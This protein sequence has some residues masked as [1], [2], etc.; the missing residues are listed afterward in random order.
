MIPLAGIINDL[1]YLDYVTWT[2]ERNAL[3]LFLLLCP[4]TFLLLN[5]KEIQ[6]GIYS[7]TTKLR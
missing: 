3:G 2:G 1:G 6:H 7:L 4:F 5:I